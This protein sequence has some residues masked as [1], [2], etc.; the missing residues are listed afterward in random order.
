MPDASGAVRAVRDPPAQHLRERAVPDPVLG[1]AILHP[2][3][4]PR[5]DGPGPREGIAWT[6]PAVGA[7]NDEVYGRLLGLAPGRLADLRESGTI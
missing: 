5:F 6:G 7:D 2:A 1:Q 3:P 4:V